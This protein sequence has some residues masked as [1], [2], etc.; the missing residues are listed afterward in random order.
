M[1]ERG[2]ELRQGM[3]VLDQNGE[4]VGTIKQLFRPAQQRYELADMIMHVETGLLGLGPDLYIPGG[5][6]KDVDESGVHLNVTSDR[7]SGER[8]WDKRPE[9]L[10]EA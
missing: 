8:G 7:I 4:K 1:I 3:D 2:F 5:A 6:I 10:P 9:G